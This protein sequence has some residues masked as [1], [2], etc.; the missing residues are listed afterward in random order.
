MVEHLFTTFKFFVS[1]Y[2][3]V[4]A[5][6]HLPEMRFGLWVSVSNTFSADIFAMSDE[7]TIPASFL[8]HLVLSKTVVGEVLGSG[9]NVNVVSVVWVWADFGF[10]DPKLGVRVCADLGFSDPK[11]GVRVCAD[12]G[13]PDLK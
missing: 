3:T 1:R 8:V 12:I 9:P 5:P 4:V 6:G 7:M 11:L 10:P 2:A 13:F